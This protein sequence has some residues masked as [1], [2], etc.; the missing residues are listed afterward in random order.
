MQ[1][2][3]KKWCLMT[4]KNIFLS[5][6]WNHCSVF[7]QADNTWWRRDRL[8]PACLSFSLSSTLEI[9]NSY[10]KFQCYSLNYWYLNFISYSF[11]FF[12]LTLLYNFYSLISFFNANLWNFFFQFGPHS[13]YFFGFIVKVILLF[14]FTHLSKI[15]PYIY[16]LFQF[17]S[18]FF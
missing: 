2:S 4:I 8:V 16:F 5:C 17:W 9:C 14:N 3:S 11:D 15:H 13:F 1:P 10:S 18:L 7:F 12:F 6:D